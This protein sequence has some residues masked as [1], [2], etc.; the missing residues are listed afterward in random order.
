MEPNE[1]G[2]RG[3]R[4]FLLLSLLVNLLILM[5]VTRFGVAQGEPP[6]RSG[7][8]INVLS[9]VT[10]PDAE[11]QRLA[12]I[13]QLMD[14]ITE[15]IVVD[16]KDIETEEEEG[17]PEAESVQS[18]P[19]VETFDYRY[20]YRMPAVIVQPVLVGGRHDPVMPESL[21]SSRWEGTVTL[22]LLIDAQG[23]LVD[24]WVEE[25][26]GREDADRDAL[27]CYRDTQWRPATVDGRP[28]VCQLFV[29]VP[30]EQ[31]YQTA[32]F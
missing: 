8:P 17:R 1:R 31:A 10:E 23:R 26:S 4:R 21:S 7:G 13:R 20:D 6:F 16:D 24:M 12:T 3:I 9:I 15:P 18:R 19:A 2:W 27:T 29:N 30:Y 25:S 5:W 32:G 11:P 14:S 22:G 28:T